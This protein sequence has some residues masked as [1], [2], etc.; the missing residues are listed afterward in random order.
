MRELATITKPADFAG[1]VALR[2]GCM[3]YDLG[4][5]KQCSWGS[6]SHTRLQTLLGHETLKSICRR[7]RKSPA[8][9]RMLPRLGERVSPIQSRF[10]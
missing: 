7:R 10:W 8:S 3:S 5:A 4:V 1:S 2:L 9:D 6:G